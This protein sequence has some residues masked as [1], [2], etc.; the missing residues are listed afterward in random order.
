MNTEFWSG[1]LLESANAKSTE[2]VGSLE[3]RLWWKQMNCLR[4]RSI[5][6]HGVTVFNLSVVRPVSVS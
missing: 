5:V 3:S 1:N 4:W 6:D 2:D